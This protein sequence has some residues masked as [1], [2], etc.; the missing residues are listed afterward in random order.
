M[1]YVKQEFSNGQVLTAEQLVHIEQG[2]VDCETESKTKLT[3]PQTVSV[4]Q[5]LRIQSINEDGTIVLEAVNMPSGG[6]GAV[7][8]VQV[9]GESIV[10]DGVASIPNASYTQFGLVKASTAGGTMIASDGVLYLYPAPETDITNRTNYY[11]PIT[12]KTLDNAVKAAMC[13]GK[14]ASWTANEQ[15]AARERMGLGAF[16]LLTSLELTEVTTDITLGLGK[17]VDEVYLVCK[18]PAVTT[19]NPC[20]WSNQDKNNIGYWPSSIL[21]TT[22]TRYVVTHFYSIK[23]V[24]SLCDVRFGTN[25]LTINNVNLSTHDYRGKISQVGT[26]YDNGFAVGTKFTVY[27]R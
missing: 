10:T 5:I 4:G 8:D 6:S 15:A 27:G 23:G 19:V 14:G 20:S 17:E 7:N 22:L 24:M 18:S 13:D 25:N 1:G 21:S 11:R 9:N 16:E 12:S 2:I 26:T 3:Q